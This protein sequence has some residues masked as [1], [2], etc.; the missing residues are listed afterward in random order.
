[1]RETRLSGSEGGAG[2]LNAPSLPLSPIRLVSARVGRP[3]EAKVGRS[4][5]GVRR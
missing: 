2:Q 4:G 5:L 1:M 3:C